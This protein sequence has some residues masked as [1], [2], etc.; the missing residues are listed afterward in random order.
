MRLWLIDFSRG[1]AVIAMI[2]FH[3]TFDYYFLTGQEFNYSSLAY[4]IGFS[5]IFISGLAL[6]NSKKDAKKFAKRFL[7]LFSYAL[8]ISGVTFLFYPNC[9]VKFGIL[10][11]FAFSTPIVYFFLDKGKWNLLAAFFVLALSPFVKH[12]NFCSLDYYPLIP[13]LS[14]Y[15]FGLYFGEYVSEY[16][17]KNNIILKELDLIAKMGRHSLTIY[18]IHQPIL[19]LFYKLM[20]GL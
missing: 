19:F 1:I 17:T 12:P 10:H 9:F 5:F 13:W 15:F 3:A 18:L 2:I 14:V 4:P 6:Y 8:L 16:L 20:L 7:K 11:F